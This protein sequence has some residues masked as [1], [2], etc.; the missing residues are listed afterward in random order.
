MHSENVKQEQGLKG[1]NENIQQEEWAEMFKSLVEI[2]IQW[3]FISLSL[4]V[5]KMFVLV[6]L[7]CDSF[8]FI[9]DMCDINKKRYATLLSV[10]M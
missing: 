6:Y 4:S 7:S 2:Y 1:L 3:A 8:H 5:S 9:F 10:Y